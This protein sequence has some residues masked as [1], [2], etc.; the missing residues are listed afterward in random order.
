MLVTATI[1]YYPTTNSL[2]KKATGLLESIRQL[3]IADTVNGI[4]WK[5]MADADDLSS[6]TED[7]VMRI[8]EAFETAGHSEETIRGI[9][10]W[11]LTAKKEHH[12]SSTKSTAEI[13]GLI[14]RHQKEIIGETKEIRVKMGTTEI[15]VTDDLFSGNYYAFKPSN[16]DNFPDEILAEKKSSTPVSGSMVFYYFTPDPPSGIENNAVKLSKSVLI[17]NSV[18]KQW[19][20]IKESQKIKIADKIKII[21]SIEAP[22]QLSY[23]FIDDKRAACLEPVD[24][25]SGYG[26]ENHLS[27]YKSVRDEGFQFFF[28]KIPSGISNIQYEL[29]A[30]KEGIF[31]NG[32]SAL[33]CMYQPE[34]SAY[35]KGLKLEVIR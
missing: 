23:V 17:Q 31:T 18:S 34:L 32:I 25:M 6:T 16:A 12:W 35:S 10:Q 11:L 2:H 15:T 5:D 4:R 7:W 8:A 13:I 22:K 24:G 19:E 1:K 30:A 21:L 28:E 20:Q 9:I 33:Q 26:Y 29:V 14:G 3:A 27:Y